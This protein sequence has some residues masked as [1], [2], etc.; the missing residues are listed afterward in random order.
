VAPPDSPKRTP[1]HR[2]G[3]GSA[4]PPWSLSDE[5]AFRQ[6]QRS[7]GRA[8]PVDYLNWLWENV[9]LRGALYYEVKDALQRVETPAVS[10]GENEDL[11][12]RVYRALA[13]KWHPDHG[14]SDDGMKALND[15]YSAIVGQSTCCA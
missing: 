8:L 1:A 2:A 3:L 9:E 6:I 14:G 11:V 7:V 15:F 12:H 4:F 13:R 10:N 5:N